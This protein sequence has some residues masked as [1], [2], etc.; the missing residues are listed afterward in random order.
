MAAWSAL[1]LWSGDFK[2][3]SRLLVAGLY[4]GF[5]IAP[6]DAVQGEAYRIIS[7]HVPTSWMATFL[8]ALM[9]VYAGLG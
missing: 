1:S 6:T 4:I 5:F 3:A 9:A 8:Y 7:M 2:W